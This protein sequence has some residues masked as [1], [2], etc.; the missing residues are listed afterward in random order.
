MK[1]KIETR[2]Q[3]AIYPL[4]LTGRERLAIWKRAKTLLGHR[5]PMMLKELKKMR[6]EWNRKIP[7]LR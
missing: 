2:K 5:T 3:T 1:Q 7:S 4:L 6:K